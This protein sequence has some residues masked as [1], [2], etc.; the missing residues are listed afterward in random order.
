MYKREVPDTLFLD[1]ELII[2]AIGKQGLDFRQ[3]IDKGKVGTPK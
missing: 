1:T 2:C 3:I